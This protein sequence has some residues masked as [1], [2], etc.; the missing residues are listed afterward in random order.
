MSAV[1]FLSYYVHF[2][3]PFHRS[4]HLNNDGDPASPPDPPIL[5]MSGYSYGAMVTTQLPHLHTILK[6]FDTPI[7][8][9]HAAEI[10]L[11]AQHLAE[12]QNTILSG[13]RAAAI[14][15]QFGRSPRKSFGLRIGG[16]EEIRHSHESKHSFTLDAEDKIRKG[17]A[18]LMAKA[19][20]G[21]KRW[22]SNSGR[23]TPVLREGDHQVPETSQ[24]GEEAK[25][26]PVQECLL[27]V[28]DHVAASPAYLL[29]S[30]L[31][32]VIT[33]LAT[34]SFSASFSRLGLKSFAARKVDEPGLQDNEVEGS[35][36]AEE[37]LIQNPT[38]AIYGDRDG[39]VAAK[40]LREWASRL[41]GVP[42][43]RFRAHEVSNA[44]H[45]WTQGK[46]AYTMRDAVKT[47]VGGLLDGDD[48]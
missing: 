47:F 4:S 48:S 23:S 44:G 7:C 30:P 46:V 28:P 12:G 14:D 36:E 37:K 21:H 20:T 16:D 31:Q 22:H 41:Q 35:A 3:D 19:R 32:G 10:R 42:D 43:S 18:E 27:P 11:R 6:P 29:I 40:R 25:P 26:D 8:L 17:V 38:L 39:F 33:N 13:A 45:F 2:L 5:I 1:G 9:S 24:G 15:R 34:M